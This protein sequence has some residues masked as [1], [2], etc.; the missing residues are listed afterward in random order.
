MFYVGLLAIF[1]ST[2]VVQENIKFFF[3]FVIILWS[4]MYNGGQL[5]GK[6]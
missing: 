1:V 6:I 3:V 5:G 2:N 4:T